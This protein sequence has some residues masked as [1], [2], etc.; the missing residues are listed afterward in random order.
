MTDQL[1]DLLRA[2]DAEPR[3]PLSA[4]EAARRDALLGEILV[5]EDASAPRFF[6]P[7]DW[8]VAGAATVLLAAAAAAAVIV[9]VPGL[10]PGTGSVGLNRAVLASWTAIPERLLPSSELGQSAT[11]WCA[12]NLQS[13]NGEAGPAEVSHLDARGDAASMIYRFDDSLYYCL[14]AGNGA[15]MWEVADAAPV[16]PLAADAVQLSSA[17]TFGEGDAALIYAVGFAGADVESVVLNEAGV[18]PVVATLEGGSWTAWWPSSDG[19]AAGPAG[20]VTITTRDGS[21]REVPVDSLYR[22]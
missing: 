17:G 1:L 9:V 18:E 7:R 13:P 2:H 10:I 5:S 12:T 6:R 22:P 14:S 8:A 15:G 20:T 16:G 11:Q 19:L 4:A 3:T 21:S